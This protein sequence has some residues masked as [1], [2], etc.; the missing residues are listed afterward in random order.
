RP[1][2]IASQF[3]NTA[4]RPCGQGQLVVCF[5][6]LP[7]T[8][9]SGDG[10]DGIPK[11][12]TERYDFGKGPASCGTV[13]HELMGVAQRVRSGGADWQVVQTQIL[14]GAPRLGNDGFGI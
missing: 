3:K 7:K 14:Q 6:Y 13:A 12:L 9:C 1:R 8:Q 4:V 2:R 10:V 11:R 5:L